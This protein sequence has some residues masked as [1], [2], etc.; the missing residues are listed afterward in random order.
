MTDV[1]AAGKLRKMKT[2]LA[3]PVQYRLPLGESDLPMNELL[4]QQLQLSYNGQIN[5]IAC[6]RKTS[7]S[8]SQGYCYPCFKRLA[9]CDS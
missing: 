6:D 5:C 4:G 8:F 7:K 3:E 2:E 9:Q 1:L